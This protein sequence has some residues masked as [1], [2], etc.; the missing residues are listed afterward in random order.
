M[1]KTGLVL[2]SLFFIFVLIVSSCGD[3]STDD[4]NNTGTGTGTSTGTGT[5]TGTG[6]STGT[7]YDSDCYA[8]FP[9]DE[10]T[11]NMTMGKGTGGEFE[12]S[13]S[14]PTWT[15]GHFNY[16]LEF[17]KQGNRIEIGDPDEFN[18]G[19]P[20]RF[21]FWLY[22]YDT[23]LPQYHYL[24][25]TYT[26]DSPYANCGYILRLYGSKISVVTANG[27]V[28]YYGSEKGVMENQWSFI[29]FNLDNDHVVVKVDGEIGLDITVVKPSKSG[30]KL[31]V[32]DKLDGQDGY[33]TNG[34]IDDLKIYK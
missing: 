16:A 33:S 26:N 28:F 3:D 18:D 19:K 32:G 12:C 4:G 29:E 15:E 14:M 2:S 8:H 1:K 22:V 23:S 10:G 30:K 21:T 9:F 13:I 31:V 24:I 11:G 20:V 25:D 17:K 7:G 5:G 34:I 6:T 27:E